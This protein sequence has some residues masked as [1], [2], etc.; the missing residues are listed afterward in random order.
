VATVGYY[1]VGLHAVAALFHHY[2][3]KDDTLKR[4]MPGK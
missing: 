3:I 4:M 1:L 2:F